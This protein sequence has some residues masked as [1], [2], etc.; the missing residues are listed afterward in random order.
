[1]IVLSA[2]RGGWG[3]PSFYT[4]TDGWGYYTHP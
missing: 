4:P 1:L 3:C 2:Y